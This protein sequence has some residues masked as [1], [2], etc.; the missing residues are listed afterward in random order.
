MKKN[1]IIEAVSRLEPVG[2]NMAQTVS[3]SERTSADRTRYTNRDPSKPG[4]MQ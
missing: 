4:A 1:E 2:Q 3:G